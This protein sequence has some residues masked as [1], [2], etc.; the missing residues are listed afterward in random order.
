MGM[1]MNKRWVVSLLAASCW[2]GIASAATPEPTAFHAKVMALS[3][4]DSITF[5]ALNR[6][7]LATEDSVA[8]AL[9]Q[10]PRYAVPHKV[11][12]TPDKDGTWENIDAQTK[13]WRYVVKTPDATSLNIG[14][15]K[16]FLPQGSSLLLYSPD[17]KRTRGPFTDADNRS[18]KEFW[19]P[20][21]LAPEL[22]VEL[23]I[24]SAQVDK[25]ELQIGQIGQGYRGFGTSGDKSGSCNMDVAC[26][27][28]NDPWQD[29]VRAVAV[30]STGGSTFCSG[31]LVNDTAGDTKMYFM[32]A[33]HCSITGTAA[34][35]VTY[36]NYQ[37]SICRLPGSAASGAAGDGALDQF[38]TG[39]TL[40][41]DNA[42]SDFTLVEMTQPPNPAFNLFWAGWDHTPYSST[43]GPGNG[44]F[45]CTPSSLCAGIH[46]PST[47]EKR[48]TF[49]AD[50]TTTTSYNN[51]AIP[52]DGSHVHALW[53]PSPVFPPNPATVI[54]PQVT[55]PGSSG[56]PLYNAQ[57]RYIGQLHGG[58][59]ACGS[60]GGNLSDYYG[61]FSVSWEGG[62]T[63]ATRLKDWLDAGNTGA[64][65]I[66][67]R[68]QCTAPPVPG[69]IAAV[70]N[71][72]NKI[73]VT[74]DAATGADSYTVYRAD[75]AC[76][77]TNWHQI[78]SNVT[79][80]T[81][82]D[83]TVSGNATYSYAVTSY[84]TSQICESAHSGCGS[85]TAT[86]ICTQSPTFAG[87][88]SAASSA[89]QTC[90]V[91]LGWSA[92]TSNCGG[93]AVVKYN[94]FRSTT[95]GF[96]PD[97]G[98]RIANCQTGTSYHDATV[99]NGTTY[100]YIVRAEDDTANGSGSCNSGNEDTNIVEQATAPAGPP[101]APGID[102][103][104]TGG[105]NWTASGSGAGANFVLA[106]DQSHSPTHSWFAP[107][108]AAVGDHS[109]A[110]TNPL[111]ITASTV[112]DFWHWFNTETGTGA[113]YDG[114]VLEYSLD[115][116]TWTDILAA[117]GTIP[118]NAG[119]ITT[120]PYSGTI[121]SAYSNPLAG[122]LAWSGDSG[123]FVHVVVDMTD[124]VGKTAWFRWRLGSDSSIGKPGYWLDDA[125][126]AVATSCGINDVIFA[127]GFESIVR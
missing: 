35:L 75:G 90:G 28:A 40:R 122:R 73:D 52:G 119:R 53:D 61:R 37:N 70:A 36:W 102:N 117:N 93:A 15:T 49:V 109:I 56:S 38:N 1:H 89:T 86:G 76:P 47:D 24:P 115:N 4:V 48:I 84:S 69:N 82:S 27:N 98:N 114:V 97:A 26:L 85:A 72:N 31:S 18:Y 118:A 108:A 7:T 68:N 54:P 29:N 41:A 58:P 62:G 88:S 87:A 95:A 83:T 33:H 17:G 92:G 3:K 22:V 34:S 32:T 125:P 20:V 11:N 116:S 74:W 50:N 51:P 71:G 9:D 66:D 78:A 65:A 2:L 107:D 42:P 67:G 94:I 127:D 14:F 101:G 124:F 45:A 60:T 10:P 13:I 8:E 30:I 80:T 111:A 99:S 46:H 23:T 19:T 120:G 39:A 12:I 21:I 64:M 112:F 105:S 96:T 6:A 77:G 103:L 104:E 91:D 44:D 25:L 123:G 121:S 110:T 16:F 57:R 43:G 5:P 81:Y 55:E 126:A 113:F 59:S 106:T 79:A 63:A 100:H